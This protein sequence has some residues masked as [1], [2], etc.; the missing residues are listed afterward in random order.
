[1]TLNTLPPL[2]SSDRLSEK[3]S[4]AVS[5]TCYMLHVA[6][7]PGGGGPALEVLIRDNDLEHVNMLPPLLFDSLKNCTTQ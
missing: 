7:S 6:L 3:L 1:M 2:I 5:V 4:H